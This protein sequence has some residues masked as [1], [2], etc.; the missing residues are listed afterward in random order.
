[1]SGVGGAGSGARPTRGP[2]LAV[3]GRAVGLGSGPGAGRDEPAR[4]FPE[5]ARFAGPVSYD[6]GEVFEICAALALAEAVLTRLGRTA[7]AARLA[8]AFEVAEGRLA[9]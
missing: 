1:M 3:V 7:E 4:S 5:P 2:R 8:A 6:K 9:G